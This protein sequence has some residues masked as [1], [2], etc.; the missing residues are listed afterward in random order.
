[1]SISAAQ[2]IP[3]RAVTG[4]IQ[5]ELSEASGVSVKAIEEFEAGKRT[6]N[7]IS[8]QALR[9]ALERA[10]CA[11]RVATSCR[12]ACEASPRIRATRAWATN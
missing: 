12:P 4:M 6:L 1:M 9:A 11:E 7:L 10:G 2:T 5:A 3:G 8:L